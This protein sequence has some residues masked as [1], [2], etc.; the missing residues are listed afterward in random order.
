MLRTTLVGLSV[1]VVTAFAAADERA[2][3]SPGEVVTVYT[4]SR[5]TSGE[6]QPS[7]D[8]KWIVLREG[9]TKA[10]VSIPVHAIEMIR[11]PGGPLAPPVEAVAQKRA[12]VDKYV[13]YVHGIC[14]HPAGYSDPW[15]AALKRHIDVPEANRREVL[16]SD[17]VNREAI[18]PEARAPQAAEL[19]R[20][21]RQAL[22]ERAVRQH[23]DL[24]G[25]ESLQR[26]DPEGILDAIPGAKCVDDFV[27]Y[28]LIPRVRTETL[29]RFTAVVT[30]LLRKPNAQVEVISHS[31]GTVVAYEGLLLLEQ[32]QHPG[33]V[34]NLFTVGS[35]LSIDTVRAGLQPAF[36]GRKPRM[37]DSWR[38]LNARYDIV[39][40]YIPG[41]VDSQRLGLRPVGCSWLPNP[42]CSH[43]SYFEPANLVVN[44]DIFGQ[45]I[46]S[47]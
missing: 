45:A 2:P 1:F 28:M 44:R 33:R 11:R 15:W 37:V 30:P 12:D 17:I 47:P 40:G 20:R 5:S 7:L 27:S 35:A 22:R 18:A 13:V 14:A 21:I 23:T 19:S 26:V 24:L 32:A 29:R 16:W 43:G 8:P 9:S 41:E 25:A 6:V 38:N 3:Y 34:H 42:S 39:G 46:M 4:A 31:W 10:L 36:A